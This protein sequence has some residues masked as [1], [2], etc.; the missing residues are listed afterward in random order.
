MVFISRIFRL[1]RALA[2]VGILLSLSVSSADA[3]RITSSALVD[4]PATGVWNT[5]LSQLNVVECTNYSSELLTVEVAIKS[6]S[7]VLITTVPFSVGGTNTHHLVLNP[8]VPTDQYGTYVVSLP[9]SSAALESRFRCTTAVY[10]F[11]SLGA[12]KLLEYGY[13][14]P[15]LAPIAGVSGGTFNSNNPESASGPVYNWL[16]IVNSSATVLSGTVETYD[17]T[18]G[19]LGVVPVS[20]LPSGGRLDI[21]LGHTSALNGG[22]VVGVYRFVPSNL[23]QEYLSFLI[24]YSARGAGF[25]FAFPLLASTGNCS[26]ESVF[27]STMNPATNWA[28]IANLG[29][30]AATVDFEGRN[31]AGDVI[32]T[33]RLTLDPFEQHHIYVNE[34]LGTARTGT[35]RISCGNSSDRV[36]MQSVFYGHPSD[37]ST[38]VAWSYAKQQFGFQTGADELLALPVNTFL[39]M[40]N[41]IRVAESGLNGGSV[42][43]DVY[44]GSSSPPN[45]QAAIPEGGS[46]DIPVHS[47]LG[48]DR[49]AGA[50]VESG[51]STALALVGDIIRVLPDSSNGIGTIIPVPAAIISRE[52]PAVALEE[53]VTGLSSPVKVTHAGDGSNR[54]F[55]V[56][57][58]GTIRVFKNNSL[59]PTPFLQ[60]SSQIST[61]GERGLL[62]LAFHPNFETNKRYFVI[63][64]DSGGD[65]TLSEF[66]ESALNPDTT[67]PGSEKVLLKIEHST[68][69]NHNGGDL[70]FG[71]DGYLYMSVGDG[72]GGG[73]PFVSGQDLNT[74]LGKILRLDIDNGTT[75]TIP[76]SNPFVGQQN[77]RGEI[78]AY[79]MRNPWRMALDSV[80]NRIFVG[81]VGQGS[82]EEVDIVTS[83][84]NY[85]W[86]V[87]EGSDCYPSGDSCDKTGKILPISEYSHSEGVSITGG[88][89][90][91]GSAI[92]LLRGKYLF[93]DFGSGRVWSIEER[94][95]GS[96]FRRELL[97][98]TNFLVSS[99]GEDEQGE[100]YIVRYQG[101]LHRLIAD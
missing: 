50:L 100:V 2:A 56:E 49:V 94:A 18:G 52:L 14:L 66:V 45:V 85:G 63:Y 20:P 59:L 97:A 72:G 51:S 4:Y 7:G 96:W 21:G 84:G 10:R 76:P 92:P 35:L 3:Q 26:S 29:S 36:L 64:T 41:W 39:G 54:L 30:S 37:G 19:L 62:S 27:A 80:T 44:D 95:D 24:R 65:V 1:C 93:G 88:H 43:I 47:V 48:S 68:F 57:Q 101:S 25:N 17:Q 13:T 87:M 70:L 71:A 82:L 69:G 5:F 74:L 40:F 81:D 22:K 78:Y 73:D 58:G 34:F 16:S 23:S 38:R 32:S 75:Y 60:I 67:L 28:E 83:G 33:Q 53:V 86:S 90:Y 9:G 61:G 11:A 99:F 98:L 46:T 79:G 77:R 8:L 12:E 15:V 91:R 89:V 6:S 42:D 55:I 31:S